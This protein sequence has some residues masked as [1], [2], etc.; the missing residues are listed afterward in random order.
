MSKMARMIQRATAAVKSRPDTL[1][2]VAWATTLCTLLI[3]SLESFIRPP[4]EDGD[5]S[6]FMYVAK[7]ILEG[8]VPYLD[9]FDNKG[10]LLYGLN[11]IGLVISDLWGVW[12]LEMAFLLSTAWLAYM[13]VKENFGFAATIFPMA[14]FLGYF[15]LFVQGGNLT[16]QYALLFQ[17]L[18][19]YLFIR[20]ERGDKRLVLPLAIGILASAAFLLRPNLV[21]LWAAIGLYWV[22]FNREDIAKRILW[23]VVGAGLVILLALGILAFVG[24]LYPFY[25]A[26]FIYN[27]ARSNAPLLERLEAIWRVGG[28]HLTFVLLPIIAS[29]CIGLYYFLSSEVNRGEPFEGVLKL[30]LVLLPIEVV[31]ASTSAFG[32]GHYFLALLPVVTVLM[33][34]FAYGIVKTPGLQKSLLS[35]V[36]L[37]CVVFYFFPPHL[38]NVGSIIEKYTREEGIIH[39]KHTRAAERIREQTGPEETILVWGYE[40][41]LYLFS[42]RDAPTRYFEQHALFVQ[43]NRQDIF[44]EFLS[45]V[46]EG[47]PALIIDERDGRLPPLDAAERENWEII[48]DRYIYIP[49]RYQ[50]FLDFVNDH[51]EFA[52]EV[53]GYAFYRKVE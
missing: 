40:P 7:G 8:D 11:V 17:F 15:G 49:E 36:L 34:F 25:D 26:V 20:V 24:G 27:F 5:S 33:G 22:F 4:G 28:T 53:E 12:L 14:V 29:W 37:L 46:Q 38:N 48:S 51:Y 23:S 41:Q 31:L 42:G 21:G 2:N 6:T 47:P 44:D 13:V 45:D 30:A 52:E 50:P 3:F 43:I 10:P 9:R 1:L 39:S 19:L 18:A 35:V 16:E 32:Y